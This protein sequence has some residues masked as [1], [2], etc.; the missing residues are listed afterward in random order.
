MFTKSLLRGPEVND[1]FTASLNAMSSLPICPYTT[2][3]D[4]LK[5]KCTSGLTGSENH[6]LGMLGLCWSTHTTFFMSSKLGSLG[7]TSWKGGLY[8]STMP[9]GGE[10]KNNNTPLSSW[11]EHDMIYRV[12][13]PFLPLTNTPPPFFEGKGKG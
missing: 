9:G 8:S 10:S 13:N 3:L 5:N 6:L 11:G 7:T 12:E 2:T 1:F 4:L